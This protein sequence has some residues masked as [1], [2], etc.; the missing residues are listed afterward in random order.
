M[1]N[2]RYIEGLSCGYNSNIEMKFKTV[3]KTAAQMVKWLHSSHDIQVKDC[4]CWN[5]FESCPPWS[6]K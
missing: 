3:V 4:S 2:L 6:W 1:K 5:I